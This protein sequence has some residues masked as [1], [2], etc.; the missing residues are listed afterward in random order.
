[1]KVLITGAKGFVGKNLSAALRYGKKE[2]ELYEFDKENS[3]EELKEYCKKADFI[4][5]FAGV[6]RPKEI[7]EYQEGNV[8]FSKKMLQILLECG[9]ICP[10]VLSSS[11]QASLT[12]R[13]KNS[14]YGKTKLVSEEL[15]L[16]YGKITG[17][18]VMIY[19]FPNLF[20]KWCKPEYN[21]VVATF[22]YNMANN[23]P[24]QINDRDTKLELAYIDDVIKELLDA[25]DGRGHNCIPINHII[26]LGELADMLKKF[27]QQPETL[28]LPEMPP[29]SF[30]KKLYSV[31]L[32]YL[33]RKAAIVSLLENKD[34]RGSFTELLKTKNCGQVSVNISKPGVTKGQHWHHSKWEVFIV[35]SGHARIQERKIGT[36]EVWEYEVSG[37]KLQAVYLLPGYTH[38]I[39]NLSNTQDL[40]TL[41]WANEVFDKE[42]PDTYREEV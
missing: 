21:S 4:Y 32:S 16:Q 27:K 31:Y 36:E 18:N 11:V 40:V 37:E 2:I 17:A 22:C 26:T 39:T 7:E 3:L 15:F 5:H 29:E 8:E 42:N 10:I 12:G 13:Y 24:I 19:R 9:N 23:L 1:M 41:M 33:P 25:L 20:G 28:I 38:N 35:V 6:N 34:E 14:E 30:Q